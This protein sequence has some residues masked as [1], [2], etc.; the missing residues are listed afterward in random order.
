MKKLIITTMLTA[1]CIF[2]ANAKELKVTS[3]DGRLVV[4]LNDNRGI[5]VYSATYDGNEAIKPS[6]L[7]LITNVGDFSSGLTWIALQKGRDFAESARG[8]VVG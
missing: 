4:T 1:T 7:G 5:P 2:A 3:P 8:R 6:R